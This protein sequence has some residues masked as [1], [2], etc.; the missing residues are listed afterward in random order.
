[1]PLVINTNVG[2]LTAQRYLSNNTTALQDSMAK[3]ASG[4]RINKAGDDAAGL[5]L[6]EKLRAQ[7]RGTQKAMDNTQDGINVL[8]IA[9]G[10]LQTITDNLQRVRELAVQAGNDTYNSAQRSAMGG[11]II[12]LLSDIDRIS[13]SSKFN[14]VDLLSS[15]SPATFILQVGAN[16]VSGVD[17]IDIH[18]AMG[19]SSASTL[20]VTGWTG[21]SL[22]SSLT[23]GDAARSLLGQIDTAL[24]T[25]NSKRGNLGAF[26]N[27]LQGAIN[28][29]S[30]GTENLSSSESRIRNVDVAAE[31]A[32]L[33]Q[34]QILQ[35]AANTILAQANQTPQLAL[36]LL[37]GGG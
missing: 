34:A 6:S 30:I 37:K 32:K 25:V 7:I 9:D 23:S 12:Q 33:S 28:N 16:S 22:T 20:G 1:M 13:K 8:N 14:G 21:S 2:S 17:T 24:D 11:E 31:S 36:S 5:Q 4:F 27:R 29:L 3:L 15:S 26:V 35:Q 18:S 19:D 10:A